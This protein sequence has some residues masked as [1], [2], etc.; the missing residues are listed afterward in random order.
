MSNLSKIRKQTSLQGQDKKILAVL[1]KYIAA[2]P[3]QVEVRSGLIG[4]D[5]ASCLKRLQEQG[6]VTPHP[7]KNGKDEDTKNIYTLSYI[8]RKRL[9]QS[10]LRRLE[11]NRLQQAKSSSSRRLRLRTTR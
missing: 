9:Q 1:A 10:P 6:L 7:S 5:V 3:L 11:G 2:T 4:V 8:G